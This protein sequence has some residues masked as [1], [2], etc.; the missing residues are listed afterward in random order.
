MNHPVVSVT[1]SVQEP[2]SVFTVFKIEHE[3]HTVGN[4]LQV[5]INS[6]AEMY[7]QRIMY[8][9]YTRRHPMDT[10]ISVK[11]R[12]LTYRDAIEIMMSACAGILE[13]ITSLL[14]QNE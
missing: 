3:S 8:I 6:M 14:H 13:D 12:T 4:L 5:R 11:L 2:D 1:S 9:A 7:P 10:Y